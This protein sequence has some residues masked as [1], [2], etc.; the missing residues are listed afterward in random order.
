[1]VPYLQC[2]R[3]WT[4]LRRTGSLKKSSLL[5]CRAST[6]AIAITTCVVRLPSHSLFLFAAT[7]TTSNSTVKVLER[8]TQNE[9]I[10]LKLRKELIDAQ[11]DGRP[12]YEELMRL[13]ILDAV[14]RE[15]LRT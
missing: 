4:P 11:R 5:R 13:P 10:Q 3:T 12:S 2:V 1:M 9:D 7:D 8:L 15:T 14:V 6:T